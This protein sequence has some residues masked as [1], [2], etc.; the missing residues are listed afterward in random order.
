MTGIP[1][2]YGD[3]KRS[4]RWFHLIVSNPGFPLSSNLDA[5]GCYQITCPSLV[6]I[7]RAHD[8]AS[9]IT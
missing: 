2:Y 3:H 5:V 9:H 6:E 1:V 4:Y 7:V 8:K